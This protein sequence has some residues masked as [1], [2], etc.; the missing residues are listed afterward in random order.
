MGL[1][2]FGCR[3]HRHGAKHL[4]PLCLI[5]QQILPQIVTD[6]HRQPQQAAHRGAQRLGIIHIAAVIRQ[7]TGYAQRLCA[8]G[9]GAQIAGILHPVQS[10]KAPGLNGRVLLRHFAHT[11]DAL[12]VLRLRQFVRHLAAD[13]HRPIGPIT[14]PGAFR[15]VARHTVGGDQHQRNGVKRMKD[16]KTKPRPL[17]HKGASVPACLGGGQQF[18]GVLN[19]LIL[20][21]RDFIHTH[22][23]FGV[24]LCSRHR[25]DPYLFNQTTGSIY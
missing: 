17:Q 3:I 14:Q 19:Q 21:S 4:E 2:N 13:L 18:F 12:G 7:Q 9:D 23:R 5:Q 8:A 15:R 11:E 6:G 22:L 1:R 25:A 20:F 10:D 16:I 24:L